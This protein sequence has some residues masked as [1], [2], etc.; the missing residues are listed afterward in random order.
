MHVFVLQES[1][2]VNK[3]A[4]NHLE[5]IICKKRI[6]INRMTNVDLNYIFPN[7]SHEYS[8]QSINTIQNGYLK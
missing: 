3:E 2:G 6:V 1:I 8:F 5:I 4:P 7:K